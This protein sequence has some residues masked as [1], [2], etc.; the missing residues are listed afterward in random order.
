V[1]PQA[2]QLKRLKLLTF[3]LKNKRYSPMNTYYF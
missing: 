3:F 2:L 1:M